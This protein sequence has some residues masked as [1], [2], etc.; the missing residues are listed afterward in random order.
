MPDTDEE[1]RA[2]LRRMIERARVAMLTTVDAAGEMRSRPL[3]TER[4]DEDGSLWFIVAVSSPKVEE[5]VL[6]GSRV[7]LSY[8]DL[9][10]QNYASITGTAELVDDPELKAG[11]WNEMAEIWFPGG[12]ADHS[13]VLLRII[14]ERGEI[15]DRP[16][17][18][19]GKLL[20]FAKARLAGDVSG[21]G[22]GRKFG[23]G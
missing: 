11:L 15:W 13:V 7:G 19:M 17:S 2:R 4:V 10:R 12:R 23:A 21:Y 6:H 20:A 22:K 1:T 14:P 5:I 3:H 16:S 8:V 9:E 18:A